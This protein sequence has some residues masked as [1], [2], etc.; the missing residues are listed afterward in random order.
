M[1]LKQL[2]EHF[3]DASLE[4]W[5]QHSNGGGAKIKLSEAKMIPNFDCFTKQLVPLQIGWLSENDLLYT[6]I[7]VFYPGSSLGCGS[8]DGIDMYLGNKGNITHV[9]WEDF[10]WFNL[11]ELKRIGFK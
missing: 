3:P 6:A 4:T 8:Y 7:S 9:S 11:E 10:W 5:H 1:T 2:Q